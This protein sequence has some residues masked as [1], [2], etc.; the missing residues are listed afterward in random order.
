MGF[1]EENQII[2]ASTEPSNQDLL[3]E[4][5]QPPQLSPEEEVLVLQAQLEAM[6]QSGY[7]LVSTQTRMQSLLHNAS[8]A[9]IQFDASGTV[10]IFNRAA[11]K[12]FGYSEIEMLHQFADA[13]F[14]PPEKFQN[15]IPAYL[16]HYA[17]TVEDQYQEPLVGTCRDGSQCQMEVSVTEIINNDMVLFDDFSDDADSSISDYEAVLCI[18]HDITE[19]KAIDAELAKHREELEQLVEEQTAEIRQAKEAAES[20]NQS[21]ST[22][23]ANMSHELR[24]P[25]H[26]ILS[27][28]EFGQKKYERAKPEKLK[29]YFDRIH[30]AG[31]RL[32]VMINDLLDLAKAEAGRMVYRLDQHNLE[33]IITSTTA[34]YESLIEKHNL[35]LSFN[36]ETNETVLQCD[37]ER[38][39]QVFTNF[40]SNAIKFSP[41]G[42]KIAVQLK[43]CAYAYEDK[44]LSGL[45]FLVKDQ[46]PGIPDEEL[47]TVFDKFVQSSN[48]KNSSSGTGLGLA[49]VREIALA[50]A[51][52]VGVVNNP[53]G[54][55]C[56][57]CRLPTQMPE[58]A[59]QKALKPLG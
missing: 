34:E 35:S 5:S 41:N 50:H 42:G 59:V 7:E 39:T 48:N 24:T 20:A 6:Q 11:E 38:I 26:A 55:A 25:M 40:L 15:N 9:I 47:K 52:E 22:F 19:R 4:D 49:I 13:L 18:F 10:S 3:P 31:E 44:E 54:G 27:Y 17:N 58:E 51:G 1:C 36:S 16:A 46:G 32:M 23:L 33:E 29:Q 28:S 14:D 30:T 43:S 53:E 8:D 56:F 45:C 37:R 21:K 2:M 12:I 57:Y